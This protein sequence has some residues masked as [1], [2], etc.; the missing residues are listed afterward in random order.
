[1]TKL[2]PLTMAFMISTP[3]YRKS[4]S[5]LSP[6]LP[7]LQRHA[8]FAL[9]RILEPELWKTVTPRF[10]RRSES[11]TSHANGRFGWVYFFQNPAT[12]IALFAVLCGSQAIHV[13]TLRNHMADQESFV[14]RK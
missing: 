1:P 12:H 10:L 13:I 7:S 2:S 6:K 14:V 3:L 9:P 4:L 11:P 5:V 8:S